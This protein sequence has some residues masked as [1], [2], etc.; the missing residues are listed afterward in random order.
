MSTPDYVLTEDHTMLTMSW[1]KKV[2]PAGTFVRPIEYAYVPKH[3]KDQPLNKLYDNNT[4]VFCYTP[5][6][7]ILLPRRLI[8][9]I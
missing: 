3:V 4:E 8:R 6:G 5:M 7:I 9:R 1:D 2:V